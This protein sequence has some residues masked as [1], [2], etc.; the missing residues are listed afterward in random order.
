MSDPL[1]MRNSDHVCYLIWLFY[2][3]VHWVR[4][5]PNDSS[6]FW[7]KASRIFCFVV[8]HDHRMPSTHL[9]AL[10]LHAYSVSFIVMDE[11]I[12]LDRRYDDKYCYSRVNLIIETTIPILLHF[13]ISSQFVY[14]SRSNVKKFKGTTHFL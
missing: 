11:C 14:C 12:A 5:E 10:Y 2:P 4:E 13:L 3:T 8:V 9:F 6:K 1:Y 7:E